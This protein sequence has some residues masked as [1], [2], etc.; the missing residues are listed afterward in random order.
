VPGLYRS[1]ALRVSLDPLL[2]TDDTFYK[3]SK[4]TAII[5]EVSK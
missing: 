2:I 3:Q 1:V 5:K 4:S